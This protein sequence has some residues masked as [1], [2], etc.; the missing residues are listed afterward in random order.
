MYC[1]P[2]GVVVIHRDTDREDVPERPP[3]VVDLPFSFGFL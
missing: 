1:L 3:P 2:E